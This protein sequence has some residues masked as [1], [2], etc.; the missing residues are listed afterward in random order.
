MDYYKFVGNPIRYTWEPKPIV[1][2]IYGEYEE[3]NGFLSLH[4]T[5]RLAKEQD[6]RDPFLNDWKLSN[7]QEYLKQQSK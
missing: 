5:L 4:H 1:G 3:L 6:K 2:K 7:E